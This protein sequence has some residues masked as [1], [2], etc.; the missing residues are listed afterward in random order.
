MEKLKLLLFYHSGLFCQIH[1]L[2]THSTLRAGSCHVQTV[3]NLRVDVSV[4]VAGSQSRLWWCQCYSNV[5]S[6]GLDLSPSVFSPRD[7]YCRQVE[8]RS[9]SWLQVPGRDECLRIIGSIRGLCCVV[10]V[11]CCM[12]ADWT[13]DNCELCIHCN[14]GGVKPCALNCLAEGYNF[15]TERSPAVIDGTRC[16][17]DSLNICINGECKVRE[18][19]LVLYGPCRDIRPPEHHWY[20]SN[21]ELI[22]WRVVKRRPG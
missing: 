4:I 18:Q 12:S 19:C 13:V 2:L 7:Y 20:R 10:C 17:A 11:L 6:V 14:P 9:Q 15:Y 1:H 5:I 21:G 8:R 3:D 22:R 16:Q